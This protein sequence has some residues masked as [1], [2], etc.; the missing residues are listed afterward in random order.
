MLNIATWCSSIANAFFVWVAFLATIGP[1]NVRR[2]RSISIHVPLWH[3]GI[4]EDYIEGAILDLTTPASRLGVVQL[5]GRDRLL[6]AVR[7]CVQALSKAGGLE[8]LT[9]ELEHGMNT[10]RWTGTYSN[11]RQLISTADAEEH[12]T[13]KQE[14]IELLRKACQIL[15]QRPTL[16][17]HHPSATTKIAPYHVSEFRARLPNVVQEAKKYGWQVDQQ[18]KGSRW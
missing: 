17:L 5:T 1:T 14:G 11:N 10:D 3:R 15:P 2:I 16:S 12:V 4:Q 7:S 13:R 6:S 8:N 18:L 9:L